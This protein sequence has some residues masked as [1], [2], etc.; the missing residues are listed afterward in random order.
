M[1]LS[2]WI[3]HVTPRPVRLFL[4][5]TALWAL[6]FLLICRW[7]V[8]ASDKEKTAAT[9]PT[10]EAAKPAPSLRPESYAPGDRSRWAYQSPK[11]SEVPNVQNPGWI[12]TPVDAF[13][14]ARLDKEGL[15]PAAPADRALL[16]RR[17]YFDLIGLPPSPEEVDA[18]VKDSDPK[19]YEKVVESLLSSPR[20][21]ER[22]GQHWLDVVRYA[23]TDGYEYDTL[24]P[25][26]WRYRDYVI[27]SFNTDKPYDRFILEQLAGDELAPGD[28][29]AL[30]AVGFNRLASW[31][32][33]AG[34]QDEDMNRN[35]V[36][37]EQTNAVGAVFMGSTLACARC[38]DHLFDPI[39]QSDYYRLQAFFAPAVSKEVSLASPEAQAAW[40]AKATVVK[41]EMEKIKKDMAEMEEDWKR[42]L[43]EAKRS[44]L[45]DEERAV[46]AIPAEQRHEQQKALAAAAEFKL[47]SRVDEIGLRYVKELKDKK[48]EM[49]AVLDQIEARMPELLPAIW[50][51]TDDRQQVRPIHVLDRGVHTAKGARVGPRVP[52]LFLADNA[53][54]IQDDPQS[55]TTGRRLALAR[56]L[57]RPENPLT[58]RVMVNRL[59]HYHFN[60]G[61]VATPNDFGAQGAIATH[62]ELLDW[63]ATEF[64]GQGFSVKA[65]HRLMV[66][67]NTYRLASEG[68][69]EKMVTAN[70]S[71][72]PDNRLFWRYNRRRIEAE[73][74]RDAI[75]SVSGNLNLK[76]GGPGVFVPVPEVLVGQ[77]YKPK[78]WAVTP[79]LSEHQRRTIYLVAKRNLR[80]PFMEAFDAPDL[81][82][83][84]A[85]REQSTHALQ[86]LELLNGHFSNSQAQAF[87]GRLLKEIG[88]NPQAIIQRA[89]QLAVGRPASTQEAQL[90]GQFLTEEAALSKERAAQSEELLLPSWMPENVDRASAAALCEFSLAMFNLPGFLYLN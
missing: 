78:Q 62:P 82:N 16:L 58:A 47:A 6:C 11:R 46:L 20:Y 32:K 51:L 77:L 69:H 72:D 86:S 76:M 65:M 29:E 83:S 5:P 1:A 17:V 84:C 33:N 27:K 66:L 87:A 80:L 19:A 37:T 3:V 90:A 81:Q 54:E 63:L 2:V 9:G 85:R 42:R 25:D 59:W 43:L 60:R 14:L 53:P 71:K 75:L 57:T 36:L 23:D 68:E 10:S 45:S 15:S 18:F 73:A 8:S 40:E 61:I 44:Q 48:K 35:E 39:K 41:A 56:W 7:S 70:L 55:A 31:R 34:N 12:K 24:R 88:W 67:S 74:V 21:G 28:Q 52:G 38:H 50:T 49:M 79:D 4:K 22:W 26:A 64:V 30:V 89:F 13:I